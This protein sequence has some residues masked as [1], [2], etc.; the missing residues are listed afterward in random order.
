MIAFEII[1]MVFHAIAFV[2]AL[3][4]TAST[5]NSE[6]T[7]QRC[8]ATLILLLIMLQC[9]TYIVLDALWVIND[10]AEAISSYEDIAWSMQ[11][12]LVA[13][14]LILMVNLI[15]VFVNWKQGDCEC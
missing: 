9:I 10:Y 3:E 8:L 1:A 15:K 14:T 13:V 12:W 4:V 7:G 6:K 2:M 5:V 11:E